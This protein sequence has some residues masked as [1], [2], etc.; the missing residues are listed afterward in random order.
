MSLTVEPFGALRD[1]PPVIRYTLRSANGLT[2]QVLT[3]AGI[4]PGC[5]RRASLPDAVLSGTMG[6][7]TQA[8]EAEEL[9][10]TAVTPTPR[11]ELSD[12]PWVCDD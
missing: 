7:N 6:S 8:W 10:L 11:V 3:Y 4:V 1:E 2:L 5:R 9:R 12:L